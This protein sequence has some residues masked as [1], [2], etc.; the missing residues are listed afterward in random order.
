MPRAERHKEWFGDASPVAPHLRGVRSPLCQPAL[1][2]HLDSWYLQPGLLDKGRCGFSSELFDAAFLHVQQERFD[3]RYDRVRGMHGALIR[4]A[5]TTHPRPY[6]IEYGLCHGSRGDGISALVSYPATSI[7]PHL[8][9]KRHLPPVV[10]ALVA[11]V[12]VCLRPFV[13]SLQS[14]E[15]YP[16]SVTVHWYPSEGIPGNARGD[17]R[18]GFHTDS[19]SHSGRRVAQRNGTPVISISCGETM[20]FWVRTDSTEFVATPLEDGSVWLWSSRDDKSGV[21]HSVRYPPHTEASG[22]HKGRGR[23]VIIARWVDTVRNYSC[24][25]PYRNCSGAECTWL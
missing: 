22:A 20:W 2:M 3:D 24:E 8:W 16:N 23:W 5:E 18:V 21:K 4:H 13:P 19:Y 10:F 25:Y 7:P 17:C 9:S 15:G 14:A 12:C 11:H 1:H 6:R